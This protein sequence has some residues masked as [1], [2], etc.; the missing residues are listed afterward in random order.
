MKKK[1]AL[2]RAA[3]AL[4][5]FCLTASCGGSSSKETLGP[6][7]EDMT[8]AIGVNGF[9]WRATLDTLSF[10]P[11]A[12]VDSAGGVII[13]DWYVNPDTPTERL[14]LTVFMLDKGLRADALKVS[15]FRQELIDGVWSSAEVRAGTALQIEDSILTRARELRIRSLK[16]DG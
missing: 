9:L 14:K 2:S 16:D 8:T 15:V 5:L 10:L 13:S 6:V 7:R 1:S 3:I 11:M 12:Q 4:V